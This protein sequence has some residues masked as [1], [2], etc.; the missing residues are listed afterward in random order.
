MAAPTRSAHEELKFKTKNEIKFISVWILNK[1]IKPA[2]GIYL[3][4]FC[5]FRPVCVFAFCFRL[6]LVLRLWSC[7]STFSIMFLMPC[8][9]QSG[10][11]PREREWV[12]SNRL[13]KFNLFSPSLPLVHCRPTVAPVSGL[14]CVHAAKWHW[15]A[16]VIYPFMWLW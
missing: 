11:H 15:H 3:H 7:R 9:I 13:S 4:I 14:M 10:L 16:V 2:D 6:N 5:V 8:F 1:Q 12:W